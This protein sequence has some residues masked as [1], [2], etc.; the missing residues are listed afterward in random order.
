LYLLLMNKAGFG[1][2]TLIKKYLKFQKLINAS[3]KP[4]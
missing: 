3:L 4:F 1:W 2:D